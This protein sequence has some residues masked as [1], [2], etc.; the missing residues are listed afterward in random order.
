MNSIN[1]VLTKR[2]LILI[3]C[4]LFFITFLQAQKLK[5]IKPDN[6]IENIKQNLS[7]D[8]N[9]QDTSCQDVIKLLNKKITSIKGAV[10]TKHGLIAGDGIMLKLYTIIKDSILFS[11]GVNKNSLKIESISTY[12]TNFILYDSFKIGQN[13]KYLKSCGL[14]YTI[15]LVTGYY[16]KFDNGWRM[17]FD[18]KPG[19]ISD[20]H[21][22]KYIFTDIWSK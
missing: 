21:T 3:S 15:N 8:K 5:K 2:L 4:I 10:D 20:T 13:Y 16:I 18:W 7:E 9:N 11:L 17:G 6:K 14:K 1:K 12:D 19:E 22:I